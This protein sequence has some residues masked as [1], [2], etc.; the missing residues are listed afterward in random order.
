LL[1]LCHLRMKDYLGAQGDFERLVRDYPESDSASSAVYRIGEAMWGQTR[2][3]DFDQ[4]YTLKALDQFMLFRREH[5]DH[6]LA[7]A[8]SR[9]IAEARS[10]LAVKLYRTGDLYVK[11]KEYESAKR[12]FRDVLTE[13]SESPVYGDAL[14]GWAVASARLGQRDTALAVLRDLEGEFSGRP[15]GLKA[16]QT[17]AQMAKWPSV[18]KRKRRAEPN[19]PPPIASPPGGG[20]TP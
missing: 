15:L 19:E 3:P 11:L 13:Y 14:I 2:G 1:G 4:E 17:R 6:W 5:P 16:A 8:A 20:Y 12:Y 10:R 18:T 7:E 9:R